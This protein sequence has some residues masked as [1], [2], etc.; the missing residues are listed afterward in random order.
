MVASSRWIGWVS[1]VAGVLVTA[2]TVA[3][4]KSGA[5]VA[6]A[7]TSASR[8]RVMDVR[9]GVLLREGAARSATFRSLVEAIEAS[10]LVVY[11]RIAPSRTR[12]LVQFVAATASFRV[13]R[14]TVRTPGMDDDIPYLGH[15][16]QHA[17]EIAG[18][19][20]VRDEPS[21]IA[22]YR[23]IGHGGRVGEATEME[24]AAA[25]AT[26]TRIWT[27]LMGPARRR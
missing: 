5:Q 6:P 1:A 9:A 7:V 22:L 14:V 27:D 4:Q 19:P 24:T 17:V 16:L 8:L 26:T 10:D 25:Q 23:R 15:E 20:E 13:L 11:V 21:L 12:G 18:A 3:A 2:D